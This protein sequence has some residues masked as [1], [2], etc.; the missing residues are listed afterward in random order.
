MQKPFKAADLIHLMKG[1]VVRVTTPSTEPPTPGLDEKLK[2][3][4]S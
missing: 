3:L 1:L 2:E 4:F